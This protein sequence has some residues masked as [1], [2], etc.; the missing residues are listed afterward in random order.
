VIAV[1]PA[2]TGCAGGPRMR[3]GHGSQE[4]DR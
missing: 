4:G 2:A 1:L 3:T